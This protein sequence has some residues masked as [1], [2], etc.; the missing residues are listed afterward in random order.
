LAA[1]ALVAISPLNFPLETLP[2]DIAAKAKNKG[3]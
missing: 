1:A 2:S 3:G